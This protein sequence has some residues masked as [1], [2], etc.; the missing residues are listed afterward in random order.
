[1]QDALGRLFQRDS[2]TFVK[3]SRMLSQDYP[4][5][6][7]TSDRL[8]VKWVSGIFIQNPL[9]VPLKGYLTVKRCKK[10]LPRFP[11]VRP[12]FVVICPNLTTTTP[13]IDIHY[14]NSF[15]LR[16]IDFNTVQ[17]QFNALVQIFTLRLQHILRPIYKVHQLWRKKKVQ[18]DL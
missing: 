8:A 7:R 16:Q 2:M 4:G 9:T 3:F 13:T 6:S 11:I 15:Q 12:I 17:L 10:T 1:M 14:D 18:V 5:P